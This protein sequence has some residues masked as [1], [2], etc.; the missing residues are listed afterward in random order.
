MRLNLQ[1][2]ISI[3]NGANVSS[4]LVNQSQKD[5][6]PGLWE[7]PLQVLVSFDEIVRVSQ[8]SILDP[9]F[10]IMNLTY[11]V[12]YG[13]PTVPYVSYVCHLT[14]LFTLFSLLCSRFSERKVPT[15]FGSSAA[16]R[17]AQ[18]AQLAQATYYPRVAQQTW[19]CNA[20]SASRFTLIRVSRWTAQYTLT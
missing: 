10:L 18:L 3:F 12:P 19:E 20:L 15:R 1:S 16:D 17:G 5:I 4:I 11:H 2:T 8:C 14:F 7:G 9:S 6:A 13:C